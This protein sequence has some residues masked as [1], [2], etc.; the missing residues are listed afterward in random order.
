MN[1]NEDAVNQVL[2]DYYK[3]FS[4]LTVQSIVCFRQGCVVSGRNGM[5]QKQ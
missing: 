4:T 2:T 1:N 3:A 5:A